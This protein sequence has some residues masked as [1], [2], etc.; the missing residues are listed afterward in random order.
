MTA[1]SVGQRAALWHGWSPPTATRPSQW[2]AGS[3]GVRRCEIRRCGSL[4]FGAAM[5]SRP[6]SWPLVIRFGP[7]LD[8]A[9]SIAGFLPSAP[10]GNQGP[11]RAQLSAPG[12]APCIAASSLSHLRFSLH[13]GRKLPSAFARGP[14]ATPPTSRSS[15][16]R[17]PLARDTSSEIEPLIDRLVRMHEAQAARDLLSIGSA[18]NPSARD[19]PCAAVDHT[20]ATDI[21]VQAT[22][23][24]RLR[25]WSWR[26][27]A[28][29]P[30]R[31]CPAQPPG[32]SEK[33][34]TF[35]RRRPVRIAAGSCE[36]RYKHPICERRGPDSAAH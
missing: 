18:A 4:E 16:G 14:P 6:A 2:T 13:A 33:S 26:D 21:Y 12:R 36:S 30:S 11:S 19:W 27:G 1:L 3:S 15:P 7:R 34:A 5:C 22:S 29:R 35:Q 17:L 24:R 8:A 9:T 32:S 25:D 28:A 20:S 23:S 31:W 10:R